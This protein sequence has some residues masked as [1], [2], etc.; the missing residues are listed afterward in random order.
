MNEGIHLDLDTWIAGGYIA[1]GVPDIGFPARVVGPISSMCVCVTQACVTHTHTL[2][3]AHAGK[4][5]GGRV[6]VDWARLPLQPTQVQ[7]NKTHLFQEEL[8]FCRLCL[9]HT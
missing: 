2:P 7:C 8:E 3:H 4:W 5:F 1:G 9:Q 6:P